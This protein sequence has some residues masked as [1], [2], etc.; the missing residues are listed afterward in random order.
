M[1][2]VF[3]KKNS[4]P[5]GRYFL[6]SDHYAIYEYMRKLTE[7][8]GE[9]VSHNISSSFASWCELACVGET[10]SPTEYIEAELVAIL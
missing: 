8:E 10:D 2:K 3:I 6:P 7:K 5:Y 1:V 4:E 9:E